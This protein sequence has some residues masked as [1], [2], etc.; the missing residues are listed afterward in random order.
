MNAA[1]IRSVTRRLAIPANRAVR[2]TPD[3]ELL[4]R[5][6]DAHDETA[7]ESLVAQHLPTVRAVCRSVLRDPNDAD[8][9]VQATFLVLV[10]RADAVRDR[11]ALGA[12]LCRVA[13]RTANRLRGANLRRGERTTPIDP[14]ST[15]ERKPATSD[16]RDLVAAVYEEIARLPERYRLAVLT[17]YAAGATTAQAA[18]QLG[19]AKGTLLTRLAWARKRLRERLSKR[20]L[21]LSG[22][23]M[24]LLADRGGIASGAILTSRIVMSGVALA[25]GDTVAAKEQVSERVSTLTEGVVRNMIGTKFKFAVGLAFL[26][27]AILGLGLGRMS[28]GP[29]EQ[30]D[31]QLQ[32]AGLPPT[33]KPNEPRETA[34]PPVA[35]PVEPRADLPAV[36]GGPGNDLVVRRPLGS[37]TK[38]VQGIGKAT[39]T[40]TENRIFLIATVRID[41]MTFTVTAD[42]DYCL[43]R[44][45]TVY[46]IITAAE[47]NG[48]LD[49]DMA[50]IALLVN[51]VTDMPFAFRIRVEDD[52]ITIKDIKFGP[53]GSPLMAD[54][55][56]GGEAKEM[57]LLTGYV[58]GKYRADPHPD[59]N[60]PAAA[61]RGS[62]P[63]TQPRPK[64]NVSSG[65]AG[66][67]PL[68]PSVGMTAGALLGEP[69]NNLPTR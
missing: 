58:T 64:K 2:T 1:R 63:Q 47:M 65:A 51:G 16:S 25:A 43:N 69:A 67:G 44:E 33:G 19:W 50:E 62:P 60:P 24:A 61:P 9:A 20:S 23:F 57:M 59:R 53:F 13:W 28:A 29:A 3:A 46:G 48:P 35:D 55:F 45:S 56:R 49:E 18:S 31:K 21:T 41:K 26:A 30:V 7:F 15:P 38:E 12:W 66:G 27:V 5:F 34:K 39:L 14:D 10:R 68:T 8:D 22:S 40:F 36:P 42:A 17:C 6:T 37:F 4:A 11:Q 52:A 32:T 54:F